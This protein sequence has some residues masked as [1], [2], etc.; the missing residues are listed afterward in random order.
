M[1]VIG[2]VGLPGSGKGEAANVAEA[3]GIPVVVMGDVIRAECRRRDLDPAQHHGRIAQALREEEG[4]DAIAARTLPRIREAAAESDRD[5]TVLVDGL[6]ST[7]E[8]DRFREAFGDDFTL[9]AIRAPFELRAERLGERG[10]DDSDA[11]LSALRERDAREID[12]GLGETLD[13]ADVE[14]DNTDS[15]AAFRER[16]REVLGIDGEASGRSDGGAEAAEAGG[17][18]A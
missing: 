18:G 7:V 5:E 17:D 16:V 1:N 12:L 6:R 2:T 15:L 3:A 11:D 10:R 4:D 13:R 9:V 14:I 8:L